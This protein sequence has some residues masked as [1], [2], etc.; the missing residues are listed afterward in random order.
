MRCSIFGIYKMFTSPWQKQKLQKLQ[1]KIF[2]TKDIVPQIL[3]KRNCLDT[4][5]L[6]ENRVLGT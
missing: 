4:F 6:D 2:A 5:C 3:S 1:K